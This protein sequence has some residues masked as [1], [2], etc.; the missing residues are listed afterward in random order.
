M[1]RGFTLIELLVVIAIIAILAA[2]LFPV[3]AKAR[4][5]ARQASCLSNTKQIGVAL[6]AYAQDF[7]E[8]MP[9]TYFYSGVAGSSP[10]YWPIDVLQPYIKNWQLN[11][12]PSQKWVGG[13]INNR[14]PGYPN[15]LEGSYAIIPNMTSN[16]GGFASPTL[17]GCAMAVIAKPAETIVGCDCTSPEI[18]GA[19]SGNPDPLW[20]T[21]VGGGSRVPKVHNDGANYTFCDGHS[22]WLKNT[23]PGMWTVRDDNAAATN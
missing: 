5:K 21:E 2:I 15:P 23:E 11:V 1:K 17:S 8:R 9:M 16:R 4:E 12:C 13:Y 7:D 10:L 19:W 3:F 22:K 18:F 20:F 6:Q 14:P